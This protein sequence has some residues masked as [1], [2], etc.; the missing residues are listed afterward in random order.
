MLPT[1]ASNPKD[2]RNFKLAETQKQTQIFPKT[3]NFGLRIELKLEIES[4]VRISLNHCQQLLSPRD[5]KYSVFYVLVDRNYCLKFG[6]L[7]QNRNGT[8]LQTE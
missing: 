5:A 8:N 6:L 4:E 2:S 7:N 1:G 3:R